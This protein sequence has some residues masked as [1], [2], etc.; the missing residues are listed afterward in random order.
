VALTDAKLN[1]IHRFGAVQ[2]VMGILL[3]IFSLT[4]L[5]P[6]AVSW[7]YA[8]GTAPAF[9]LALSINVVLGALT[10]WPVR[11]SRAELKIRDGFLVTVLFW[12]VLGLSG[13]I[14]L[15]VADQPGLTIP[16]AVFESV[17][18][19]TTTGATVIVGLDGLPKALLYYRQQLQWFGGMGLVILAIA[20]LPMLGVGGMQLYRAESLGPVKDT[21]LTPRLVETA[22]ALWLIYLSLT[23]ACAVAYRWAGMDWFDAIGH[24]FSTVSTGGFSTHDASIAYFDSAIIELICIAF[25][26]I[27]AVNFGLHFVAF[28]S[29]SITGYW[30]DPE[31]RVFIG[32]IAAATLGITALL[33]LTGT[34][35]GFEAPLQ[36]LFQ[37]VSI[38][39]TA[40]FASADLN[41]WPSM[42]STLVILVS[43]ICGC[44]YS[45]A[46]GLKVVRVM[47]LFKQ[48]LRSVFHNIH[49]SAVAPV[50]LGAR[51]V[52]DEVIQGVWGF[53]SVYIGFYVVLVVLMQLSGM[54][55]VTAF[56]AVAATINNL[57][58]GLGEVSTSFSSVGGFGLWLGS[59]AMLLG[60]LEIFPLLVLMTPYFWR[61]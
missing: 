12:M 27:G 21:K 11:H 35:W 58:P 37:V 20:I 38:G 19:L 59:F 46:G 56:G 16:Q 32:I 30:S 15:Y 14:P 45:T 54:D 31:F 40:G 22:R 39:T 36:A 23:I 18:G 34:Y 49:P 10:W 53:F 9:A 6:M 33:M 52:P 55:P 42:I 48:G 1:R 43:F 61:R 51:S 44:A 3:M 26:V 60:R 57:G 2:R 29:R 7:L 47:L 25:M 24:S 41:L 4:M 17:S 8:D 50:K 28:R 5:P 13:A